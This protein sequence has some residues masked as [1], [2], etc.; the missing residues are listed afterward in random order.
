MTEVEQ[1]PITHCI[2]D[3]AVQLVVVPLL[4]RLGLFQSVADVHQELVAVR[5]VL[6]DSG[7]ACLAR[8]IG[9][10]R[11]WVATIHHT[12]WCVLE[13]RLVGRIVDVLGPGQPTEPLAGA[14]VGEAAQVYD[15][16][17]V[18]CFR[19]AIR[20]RMEGCRHVQLGAHEAH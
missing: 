15:D 10:N 18:G 3:R 8:L 14:V 20:L 2:G 1:N 12:E 13:R 11:Q 7:H 19:L 16:D 6:G 5:H 9:A 4:D 17:A